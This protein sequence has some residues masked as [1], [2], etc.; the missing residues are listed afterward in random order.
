MTEWIRIKGARQHNLQDVNV[1]FPRGTMTAVSG[2]C[3][4]S[5]DVALAEI[6]PSGGHHCLRD[7]T[8]LEM[9]VLLIILH[10]VGFEQR[11]SVLGVVSELGLSDGG[12]VIFHL[13]NSEVSG[14]LVQ[15]VLIPEL[16]VNRK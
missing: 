1:D 11:M 15:G 16:S 12:V 4:G 3:C 9:V 7:V 8:K 14:N 2:L 10:L 5:K 6:T 13:T